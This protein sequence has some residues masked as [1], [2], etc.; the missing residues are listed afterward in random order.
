M[1][2]DFRESKRIDRNIARSAAMGQPDELADYNLYL[3]KLAQRDKNG[4]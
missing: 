3:Q 2:D 1:R 4:S